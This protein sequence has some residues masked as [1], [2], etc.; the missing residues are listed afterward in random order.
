MIV[1]SLKAIYDIMV[2]LYSYDF[3]TISPEN[4]F[5]TQK[6]GKKTALFFATGNKD[7]I[8]LN[9]LKWNVFFKFYFNIPFVKLLRLAWKQL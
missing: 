9:T 4:N 3:Q 6:E 8:S 2:H 1:V 7:T 5:I